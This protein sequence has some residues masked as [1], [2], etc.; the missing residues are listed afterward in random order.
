MTTPP[1]RVA[2]NLMAVE[3]RAT[4][5]QWTVGALAALAVHAVVIAG[6][7]LAPAPKRTV[8]H[9]G[10]EPIEGSGC[11]TI[12]SPCRICRGADV[13]PGSD[14]TKVH[15]R[16]CPEPMRRLLRRKPLRAPPVE[17][18]LLRAEIVENLGEPTGKLPPQTAPPKPELEKQAAR[19]HKVRR[20]VSRS[21]LGK[22]LQGDKTSNKR[23]SK[24]GKIIGTR[25]G[26]RGGDA[27]VSRK[28]SAYVREVRLDMQ[29]NFILPGSVPV[30]LRKK[31]RARVRITR[32]TATGGVLAYKVTRKSGNEAFDRTV[33]ALLSGYKAGVRRLPEPPPHILSEI[34]SRGLLIILRG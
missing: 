19:V 17:V 5:N 15:T 9:D 18:D 20:L 13:L 16:R 33:R 8:K 2:A 22:L 32:M 6:M 27:L 1:R 4:R 14:S 10:D 21:K 7:A 26:R 24:L 12:V 25:T 28:G 3:L 11:T 31:L 30:W 34:N 23:R 29:R